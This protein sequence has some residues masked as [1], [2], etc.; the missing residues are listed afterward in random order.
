MNGYASYVDFNCNK[1]II[2]MII[3]IFKLSSLYNADD[4]IESVSFD[5]RRLSLIKPIFRMVLVYRKGI[6]EEE[7]HEIMNA[8]D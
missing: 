4:R 3:A 2:W 1:G 7:I 6:T 5:I 8:Y